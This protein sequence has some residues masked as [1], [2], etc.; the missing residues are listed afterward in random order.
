MTFEGL[1]V[2][3]NL[4]EKKD[5]MINEMTKFVTDLKVAHFKKEEGGEFLGKYRCYNEVEW[6][7][8]FERKVK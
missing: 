8:Y 5:K 7:Q 1:K 6:K 4:L 2:L 3:A